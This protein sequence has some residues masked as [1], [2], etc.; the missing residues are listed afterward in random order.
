MTDA[1]S[2]L[3]SEDKLKILGDSDDKKRSHEITQTMQL[4][5][6]IIVYFLIKLE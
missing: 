3:L 2:E 5:K 1:I 6:D 4:I